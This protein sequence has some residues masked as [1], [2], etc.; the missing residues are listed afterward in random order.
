M[1]IPFHP[2]PGM[3]LICDYDTGFT[4]PEM[5]KKRRVIVVS[6]YQLNKRGLC[7]IVPIS[8]SEPEPI[9]AYH[10]PIKVGKYG[11]LSRDKECWVKGDMVARVSFDRLDR[12][13]VGAHFT[14]PSIDAQDLAEV[15]QAISHSL[16]LI[17]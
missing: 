14:S 5:V 15:R 8:T 1:P 6:P 9:E 12:L 4:P 7:T 11:F 3:V 13:R 16:G 17:P 2:K 10:Y